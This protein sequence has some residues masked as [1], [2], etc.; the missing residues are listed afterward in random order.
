[1]KAKIPKAL[2]EQVWM[3]HNGSKF[4]APCKTTWCRNEITAFDFHVGH[5]I[6]ES[7]GGETRI[8]NLV[9]ICARCNTSMGNQYTFQ[10][11]NTKHAIVYSQ[12]TMCCNAS[13]PVEEPVVLSKIT[14][15]RART[16]ITGHRVAPVEGPRASLPW[17]LPPV[18][19][20]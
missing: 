17:N 3:S 16:P 7:R 14:H 15:V 1:M 11:W 8:N 19:R 13:A 4:R 5:D 18:V 9:P 12:A 2:R 6:P 10:E 20:K